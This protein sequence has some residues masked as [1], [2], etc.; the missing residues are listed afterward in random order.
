LIGVGFLA[1]IGFTMS[2]FITDLAFGQADASA[3]AKI[4]ILL[5]SAAAGVIGW[6]VLRGIRAMT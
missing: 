5:G 2:L 3:S 6:S 1:G 4:G